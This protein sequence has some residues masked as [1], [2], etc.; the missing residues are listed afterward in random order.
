MCFQDFPS[1]IQCI[2]TMK[3][4]TVCTVFTSNTYLWTF[5][6]SLW[7]CL[8]LQFETICDMS[9]QLHLG[10]TSP[11]LHPF[12]RSNVGSTAD[13]CLWGC[14]QLLPGALAS[15]KWLRSDGTGMELGWNWDDFFE[16]GFAGAI[17]G[18]LKGSPKYITP[19]IS[20]RTVST[21]SGCVWWTLLH[22]PS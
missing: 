18:I 19:T 2:N 16:F 15:K 20:H 3:V 21:A 8:I 11:M 17:F 14:Q 10:L 12:Q 6:V 13:D 4:L 9:C 22:A 5:A 7:F 1:I